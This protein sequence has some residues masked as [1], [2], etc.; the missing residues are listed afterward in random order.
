MTTLNL[1]VAASTDDANHNS[2]TTGSGRSVASG[3]MLAADLTSVIL[4]PGSHGANNEYSVGARFLNITIPQGTT[5]TSATFGMTPQAS[6]SSPGTISYL[7]SGQAADNAATFSSGAN[8]QTS[9]RARTTAVSSPWDQ[10]TTT[11]D[12]QNTIDVTSVVQEIINRAGWVSGN[13]LVIIV[14]TNTTTT[15]GEWQD[16]NSFDGAPAKAPTL[17]I[18][19]SGGTPQTV[20]AV[21]IPPRNTFGI[22]NTWNGV[23]VLPASDISVGNWKTEA[24]AT[25][26][27]FQSL[28]ETNANDADYI[29]S[30]LAPNQ[31]AVEIKFASATD[32][33][34][35]D[36]HYVTYRYGKTVN[37][38]RRVDQVIYFK[39]GA[40]VIAQ[41]TH[42]DVPY[43]IT[44]VTQLLTSTQ[45]DAITDY[46]DLRLRI[47]ATSF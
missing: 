23:G 15:S 39:S 19:Y 12:V 43:G 37:N 47:V 40:T 41:W 27:L 33:A 16:Y 14:D 1:Q 7:V 34:V 20:T 6:Y 18:V 38:G 13:A 17:T 35:S 24:G 21:G 9:N 5:I 46:T 26:N 4:S 25:S 32:P 3:S 2:I 8:L 22:Q 10:K 42:T 36:R 30:E 45:T 29:I 11:V 28:D 44:E 31:S